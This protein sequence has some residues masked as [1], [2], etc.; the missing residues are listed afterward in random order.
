MTSSSWHSGLHRLHEIVH[1]FGGKV[2]IDGD[3]ISGTNV[4]FSFPIC[5]E[6]ANEKKS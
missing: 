6:E 4:R 1:L 3:I 5:L 2:Q